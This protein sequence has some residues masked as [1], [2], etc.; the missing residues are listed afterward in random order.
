MPVIPARSA[1]RCVVV[2]D[3]DELGAEGLAVRRIP[4]REQQ[5]GS[6]TV[7]HAEKSSPEVH[8]LFRRLLRPPCAGA[9]P[10]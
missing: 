6:G 4:L 8:G 5:L 7:T 2:F 1:A 9:F 3:P 10:H